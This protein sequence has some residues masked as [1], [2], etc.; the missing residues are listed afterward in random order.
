MN[1]VIVNCHW[2]NRGDESAI[3]AMIDELQTRIPDANFYVQRA[4]GNFE[5]FPETENV[6]II[7]TF[8]VG[9][10]RGVLQ[11]NLVFISRG[12]I[13]TKNAKDIL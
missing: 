8:P 6:K 2:G 4:I 13:K 1:I 9:G 5:H 7:P 12:A 11:D 3:R 10:R